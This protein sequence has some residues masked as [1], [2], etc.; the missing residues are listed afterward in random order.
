MGQFRHVR[1]LISKAGMNGNLS[2]TGIVGVLTFFGFIVWVHFLAVAV[3]VAVVTIHP[4]F[5]GRLWT[6]RSRASN[7]TRL[8]SPG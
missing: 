4:H 2:T 3:A 7:I 6:V 8:P 1:R 5:K